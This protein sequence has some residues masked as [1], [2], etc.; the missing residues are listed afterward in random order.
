M[1]ILWSYAHSPLTAGPIPG[2]YKYSPSSGSGSG[3]SSF[4]VTLTVHASGL[5]KSITNVH[6]PVIGTFTVMFS[7]VTFSP[8][9]N[10]NCPAVPPKANEVF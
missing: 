4:S 3:S 8:V 10:V 1:V 6:S 2:K 9:L 7:A 5:F